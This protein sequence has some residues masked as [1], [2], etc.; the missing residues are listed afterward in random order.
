M[1]LF[2]IPVLMLLHP[3]VS[4]AEP[5]TASAAVVDRA[6][7]IVGE[8]VVTRSDIALHSALSDV[9]PSFVPI[10]QSSKDES[11]QHTIDAAIIRQA[12]GRVPVYQPTAEQVRTRMNRFIDQWSSNESYQT[13]LSA[14][15]LTSDR[16]RTVLKRRAMIERVVLRALGPPKEDTELWNARFS[17]W[18][19]AE[20]KGTRIQVIPRQ[21]AP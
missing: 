7:A 12:A 14:H 21:D 19:D 16:I 3:F 17:E 1:M 10:L 11:V 2:W 8:L 13:F 18:M 20:R 5:R 4:A 9:D 6:V 15:G